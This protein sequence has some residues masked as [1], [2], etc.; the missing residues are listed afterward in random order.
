MMKRIKIIVLLVFLLIL[1]TGCSTS[2]VKSLGFPIRDDMKLESTR[3]NEVHKENVELS[4][5]SV[6]NGELSNF[7]FEYEKTL[8]EEGWETVQ[9]LKP[10]GLVVEKNEK[11][12]TVI[13]YEENNTLFVDVIPTPKPKE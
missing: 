5:Y 12:V 10:N 9:N 13:A 4:T 1:F 6:A 2:S 11:E 7:L 8:N 3:T